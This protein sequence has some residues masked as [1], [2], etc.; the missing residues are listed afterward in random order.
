[1]PLYSFITH[2]TALFFHII[3]IIIITSDLCSS[4]R[5]PVPAE[6]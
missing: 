2:F 6:V 1:M 5:P 4:C 3:I